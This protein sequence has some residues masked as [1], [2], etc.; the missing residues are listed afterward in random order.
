MVLVTKKFTIVENAHSKR[1]TPN[2]IFINYNQR[3][4]SFDALNKKVRS[5]K[6]VYTS[7]HTFLGKTFDNPLI[8]SDKEKYLLSFDHQEDSVNQF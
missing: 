6:S 3:L 5:P 4:Y 8:N 1:K 7:L 2:S